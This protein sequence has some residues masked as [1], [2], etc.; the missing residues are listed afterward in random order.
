MFPWKVTLS[1]A[2]RKRGE[3]IMSL[4]ITKSSIDLGIVTRNPEP[5]V[6]FYRDVLG[7]EY[8]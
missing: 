6:A 1:K 7:L 8:T 4:E 5:M 2:T 3:S